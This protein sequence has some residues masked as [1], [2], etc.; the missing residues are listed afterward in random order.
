MINELIYASGWQRIVK[1]EQNFI[2]INEKVEHCLILE[3]I[4]AFKAEHSDNFKRLL[5]E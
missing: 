4:D 2:K 5:K 1:R 3:E